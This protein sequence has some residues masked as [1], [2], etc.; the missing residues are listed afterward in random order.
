M[1]AKAWFFGDQFFDLV[2]GEYIT[3]MTTACETM[4]NHRNGTYFKRYCRY[5]HKNKKTL[6]PDFMSRDLAKRLWITLKT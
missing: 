4:Q 6:W 2:A 5:L 3:N 1:I